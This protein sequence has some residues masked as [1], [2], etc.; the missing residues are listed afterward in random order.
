LLADITAHAICNAQRNSKLSGL[1][2]VASAGETSWYD[3]ACFVLDAAYHAGLQ[4][5]VT[6]DKIQ[7]VQSSAFPTPASRPKNSR[8]NTHQLQSSFTL[9][10]PPW[11]NG[12]KRLLAE[13][14]EK[15]L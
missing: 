14:L 9:G 3:Y 8:L 12:V 15:P 10:L 6:S 13:I 7:A 2:H 4:L 5:K 11:Q 1:Y